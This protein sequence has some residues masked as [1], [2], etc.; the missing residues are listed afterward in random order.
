MTVP[1]PTPPVHKLREQG[2][3]L[4]PSPVMRF[5]ITGEV[6]RKRVGGDRLRLTRVCI[7][8]ILCAFHSDR[9]QPD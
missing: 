7:L 3:S 1:P 8:A 5:S 6:A 2:E 4:I 9:P